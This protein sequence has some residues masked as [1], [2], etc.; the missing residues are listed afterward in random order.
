MQFFKL[1]DLAKSWSV[2]AASA[3]TIT[4]VLDVTTPIFNFIP[5]QYKPIA[6]TVLG[7]V[8]LVTRAIKQVKTFGK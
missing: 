7:L 1:K 5:E 2:W 6:I 4:P 8:T 3:V